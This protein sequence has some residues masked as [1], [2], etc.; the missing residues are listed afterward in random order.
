MRTWKKSWMFL[1]P[2]I[3][4][5]GLG[6]SPKSDQPQSTG[7]ARQPQEERV[8][9]SGKVTTNGG[10]KEGVSITATSIDYTP[11]ALESG[12][13]GPYT[14]QTDR[15]GQ[16]S[17][18][19]PAGTYNVM[20]SGEGLQRSLRSKVR[21]L[22]GTTTLDFVLTATGDL[23]G[24][25]TYHTSPQEGIV[26]F[27]YGTQFMAV[28]DQSG[29]FT[30]RGIPIGTYQLGI[31]VPDDS[32]GGGPFPLAGLV[33][34]DAGST[35]NMGTIE[36]TD[37]E[38]FAS[39][40][41]V[42]PDKLEASHDPDHPILINRHELFSQ[43][44]YR[45]EGLMVKFN[46]EMDAHSV[47][48]AIQIDVPETFAARNIHW[49]YEWGYYQ[50]ER[51]Q[52]HDYY[53]GS[54]YPG[55]IELRFH[56]SPCH[57]TITPRDENDKPAFLKMPV[58]KYVVRIAQAAKDKY[59]N[60]LYRPYTY[61]FEIQEMIRWAVN[62]RFLPDGAAG[63]DAAG[64]IMARFS[65]LIDHDSVNLSTDLT[66]SPELTGK[67][68]S[69]YKDGILVRGQFAEGTEYTIG[70]GSE[71]APVRTIYGDPV[72]D[73]ADPGAQTL[74]IRFTTAAPKVAAMMP[75]H[76]S[77]GYGIHEP[78]TLVFNTIT[79]RDSVEKHIH[80]YNDTD[81]TEIPAWQ[82]DNSPS[83]AFRLD[84][85][86]PEVEG[87]TDWYNYNY[88][89][90]CSDY[91]GCEDC[92][93]DQENS[94]SACPRGVGDHLIILFPRQYDHVYRVEVD[95]D[96]LSSRGSNIAAF[97]GSFRTRIPRLV[98]QSIGDG[99]TLHDWGM[100]NIW[101]RYNTG[102][103]ISGADIV[104]TTADGET[105]PRQ[106]KTWNNN[107]LQIIPQRLPQNTS[108]TLTLQNIKA[109]D[110]TAIP[111]K[112]LQ[113][114]TPNL[115]MVDSEPCNGQINYL[116]EPDG[117]NFFVTIR[118]SGSLTEDMKQAIENSTEIIG[119][120]YGPDVD[121]A[122]VPQNYPLPMFV[123]C[124]WKFG[125]SQLRIAFTM[126]PCANY[127]VHWNTDPATNA[128]L[129]D[130]DLNPETA[131][132]P[133]LRPN[134]DIV[135]TTAC[136][137]DGPML[138]K[139]LYRTDPPEGSTE[140]S[141]DSD[142]SLYFAL[143]N[144]GPA[145][146]NNS[147]KVSLEVWA[148]GNRLADSDFTVTS[149][150]WIYDCP[151]GHSDSMGNWICDGS[152]SQ[153][154]SR[155]TFS[156]NR[157][158]PSTTYQ[159]KVTDVYIDP[160]YSY[161][162]NGTQYSADNLPPLEWNI[163]YTYTFTTEPS[164]IRVEVDNRAGILTFFADSDYFKISDLEDPSIILLQ[165][166]LRTGGQWE[167]FTDQPDSGYANKAVLHYRPV[168]YALIKIQ[169]LKALDRWTPETTGE[170]TETV[171]VWNL[172]GTYANTPGKWVFPVSPD[173]TLPKLERVEPVNEHPGYIRL[174]FNVDMDSETAMDISHYRITWVG[175]GDVTS[176]LE[177][178]KVLDYQCLES[179][180]WDP[181]KCDPASGPPVMCSEGQIVLKT[182]G[183]D[184]VE[185][186]LQVTG[187]KKYTR[188]YEILPENGIATFPGKPDT[189]QVVDA[190]ALE[191]V[192]DIRNTNINGWDWYNWMVRAK[193]FA[194]R[195]NKSMNPDATRIGEEITITPRYST[196]SVPNWIEQDW[197]DSDTITVITHYYEGIS[198]N[199]PPA[200]FDI[201][202]TENCK[203]ADGHPLTNT[204][205]SFDRNAPDPDMV[206]PIVSLALDSTTDPANPVARVMVDYSSQPGVPEELASLAGNYRLVDPDLV[207]APE[208]EPNG[209][210]DCAGNL[211]TVD[212]VDTTNWPNCT[213]TLSKP[214][215]KPNV[216]LVYSGIP[217]PSV[218]AWF[219]IEALKDVGYSRTS[220]L[221]PDCNPQ[222][223]DNPP[224]VSI[225]SP[226]DLQ[227]YSPAD[228]ITFAAIVFDPD[229][230]DASFPP[231][232][233]VWTDMSEPIGTGMSFDTTL[234]E[235]THPITVTVT[236]S[237]GNVESASVTITV[238]S[239]N[240]PPTP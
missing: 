22:D 90:C 169:A 200:E 172:A 110:G 160:C 166:D 214:P 165:P 17:M 129:Y 11:A 123:W 96:A 171:T 130:D 213:L 189:G 4:L 105:I 149:V 53:N 159:I 55:P 26:A 178:L 205:V 85:V 116:L 115:T 73:P 195:F 91:E 139:L 35:R 98:E 61:S 52:Y 113:F 222:P 198:S 18:L 67:E 56:P 202:V 44:E 231:E 40:D 41:Y 196:G 122:S 33:S 229:P 179:N 220:Y 137:A 107:E 117:S 238:Q 183:Q 142:V 34:I 43:C 148:G 94:Q 193:K 128:I 103:D 102:I 158:Q 24:R 134:Q 150:F 185:Y 237:T 230:Q 6:C 46:R 191:T 58:G 184:F 63:I 217:K 30:I 233:I 190:C 140:V 186:T 100:E 218:P 66:I 109:D 60:T 69:W 54:S 219:P 45:H 181:N 155:I 14:T 25:I 126:D 77:Q 121:P 19:L 135:F 147:G 104:L 12:A 84:W 176:E 209:A 5:L 177:V 23:T 161:Y 162:D 70:L 118:F 174:F 180:N 133:F 207:T 68:V 112:I 37:I 3:F 234:Q 75:R 141:L 51:E 226:S 71:S 88:D 49:V 136:P 221:P 32:E 120:Y 42:S 199:N 138:P 175:E 212:F 223:A 28:T 92:K 204:P 13:S 1:L 82:G 80:V 59:G 7:D 216:I 210:L 208:G 114:S 157:L 224:T 62:G 31:I 167:V 240:P 124:T 131:A 197:Y 108:F 57:L 125:W 151:N 15:E 27:L 93:Q 10:L 64:G 87:E 2:L 47:E 188:N 127:R 153:P 106:I 101:L 211:V 236:D 144:L 50:Y 95:G 29:N 143:P 225:S 152:S 99:E 146:W 170:G 173:I 201:T 39:V 16:Y 132:V 182:A 194:I 206:N 38:Q 81:G 203:N 21:L 119:R 154:G 65:N 72:I 9:L 164:R 163:P 48:G 232:R 235:G 192:H 97:S 36:G 83:P 187:V 20:A 215:A 89:S 79:D 111:D 228:I 239:S 86:E 78:V 227:P 74:N 145:W 8:L 168:Q 156:F 76:D